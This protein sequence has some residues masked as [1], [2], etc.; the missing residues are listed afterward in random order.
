M[1]GVM[2]AAM[3]SVV[4]GVA[5]WRR[6]HRLAHIPQI[7]A[8]FS[9][10]VGLALFVAMFFAGYLASDLTRQLFY[11]G[12]PREE[13]ADLP[14]EGI[15]R[16]TVGNA[17]GQAIVA[18][19]YVVL[20]RRASRGAQSGASRSASRGANAR[21]LR[22]ALLGAGAMVLVW[23]LVTA[24]SLVSGIVA[25]Q[26]SGEPVERIAHNTLQKLVDSSVDGWL[27]AMSTLV[28]LVVPV[29]EEVL[30]RGILQRMLG[31]VLDRWPAIIVTSVIF[32]MMHVGAAS[33]HALP[34][35]FVLSIGFGWVYER[36]QSLV[37]PIIMHLLFNAANLGLALLQ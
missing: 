1:L 32:A 2:I 17:I 30:Y 27:V 16:L 18:L 12:L 13:I 31:T 5:W 15:V 9:P 28:V 6:W 10:I 3:A 37:A 11:G 20:V 24:T 14:L 23:P 36:T 35:L 19:I 34:A 21:A 22:A 7:P 26:L 4:I 8:A 33:W 25:S 29:L